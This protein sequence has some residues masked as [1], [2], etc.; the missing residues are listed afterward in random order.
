[1][2]IASFPFLLPTFTLRNH[3]PA[4]YRAPDARFH[5]P[6]RRV[7]AVAV[8]FRLCGLGGSHLVDPGLFVGGAGGLEGGGGVGAEGF[9]CWFGGCQCGAAKGGKGREAVPLLRRLRRRR[10]R[11]GGRGKRMGYC[12]CCCWTWWLVEGMKGTI[13]RGFRRQERSSVEMDFGGKDG[14]IMD[15]PRIFQ[16]NEI[17]R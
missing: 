9:L 12:F 6:D 14:D 15:V 4:P 8:S 13:M 10:G 5:L 2:S 7:T 1:M 11:A 17:S 3:P 16:W